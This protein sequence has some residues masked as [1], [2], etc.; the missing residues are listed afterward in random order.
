MKINELRLRFAVEFGRN[1]WIV[2]PVLS[3]LVILMLL[4]GF[5]CARLE[6]WPFGD[7]AYFA[8]ITGFTVGYGDFVP[9]HPWARVF[10]IGDAFLGV[11]MTAI[12]AAA[13]VQALM[14]VLGQKT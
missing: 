3:A 14:K 4:L 7:G 8:L 10:A 1:L 11:V 13:A 5:C 6:N 12:I 9:H 2:W